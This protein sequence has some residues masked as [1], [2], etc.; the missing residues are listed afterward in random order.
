MGEKTTRSTSCIPIL[1]HRNGRQMNIKDHISRLPSFGALPKLKSVW[2]CVCAAI[3]LAVC[4]MASVLLTDW[5][6]TFWNWLPDGWNWLTRG[7]SGSATIRNIG[8]LVAAPIALAVAVWRSKVAERQ[9]ATSDRGL[10][11]ERYQKAAEMLG[12]PVLPVRL[13]GIYALQ[14]LAQEYP[15]EYHIHVM[16]LLCAFVRSPVFDDTL[17]PTESQKELRIELREDVNIAMDVIGKRSMSNIEI[18][19]ALEFRLDLRGADLRGIMLHMADLSQ[20][21]F[22]DAQLPNARIWS[23]NMSDTTF[24]FANLSGVEINDS[25]MVGAQLAMNIDMSGAK[26]INSDL[27]RTRI[28][29]ADL[30]DAHIQYSDFSGGAIFNFSILNNAHI[31]NVNLSEAQILWSEMYGVNLNNSNLSGT[32]FYGAEPNLKLVPVAGLTQSQLDQAR[33]DPN[34]PPKVDKV[35]DSSTGKPLIWR[36]KPLK[37]DD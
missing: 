5:P 29:H 34:N 10:L 28:D 7:E 17:V 21:S 13:G 3:I 32:D 33:A 27:R 8:L 16:R 25:R 23:T 12:S 20:A 4:V 19:R 31:T 22:D 1:I 24:Y 2:A 36:G 35:L 30:S 18:E 14:S 37:D 9:A 6:T 11:N 15:K 26:I